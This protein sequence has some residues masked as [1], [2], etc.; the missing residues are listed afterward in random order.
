MRVPAMLFLVSAVMW[1]L[2]GTAFALIA[3]IKATIKT[4]S[5]MAP[6]Q[7]SWQKLPELMAALASEDGEEGVAAFREKRAQNW[8]G[9]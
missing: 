4:T 9:R 1:L 3:A 5:H 7:A 6:L 2:A 8:K